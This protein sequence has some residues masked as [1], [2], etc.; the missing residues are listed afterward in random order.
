VAHVSAIG[1]RNAFREGLLLSR[2]VLREVIMRTSFRCPTTAA[3]VNLNLKDDA[4]SVRGGWSKHVE[5]LCPH[6]GRLH[7]ARYRDMYVDGVLTG[8]QDDFDKLLFGPS[9]PRGSEV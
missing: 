1:H 3:L 7:A 9:D 8:F 5:L 6:C 4:K 2:C